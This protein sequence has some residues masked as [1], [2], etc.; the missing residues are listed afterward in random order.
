MQNVRE[1][2]TD[3]LPKFIGQIN[4]WHNFGYHRDIG[5]PASYKKALKDMNSSEF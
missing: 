1:I 3:I 5:T 4:T 2:S